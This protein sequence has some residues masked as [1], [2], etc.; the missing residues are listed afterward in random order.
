[1]QL[2]PGHREF[3]APPSG[4]AQRQVTLLCLV[5][6]RLGGGGK[7]DDDADSVTASAADH[8]FIRLSICFF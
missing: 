3:S 7:D 2:S 4:S 6:C 5:S 8:S 1:M